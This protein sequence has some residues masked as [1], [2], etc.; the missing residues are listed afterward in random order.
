MSS[1]TIH[2]LDDTLDGRLTEEARKRKTSKNKLVKELLSKALG[3][4]I[5]GRGRDEY[6]EFLGL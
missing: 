3:L 4:P 6:D 1:I 2:D 5:A